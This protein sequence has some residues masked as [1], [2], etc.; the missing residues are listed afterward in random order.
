MGDNRNE[1]KRGGNENENDN[2][3]PIYLF[4]YAFTSNIIFGVFNGT[5][6]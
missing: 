6:K 2:L 3:C 5:L 1:N 4:M